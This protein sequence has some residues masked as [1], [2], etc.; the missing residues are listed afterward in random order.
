MEIEK[1]QIF[2]L[3]N[4]NGRRHDVLNALKLYLEILWEI[5]AEYPEETWKR[6]P[7]SL[8]QFLFYQ[9][10]LDYSPEIFKKH[11]KYDGFMGRLGSEYSLFL[12]RN[13]KWLTNHFSSGDRKV[14]DEA[15]EARARHY[16]SNL[17]KIG[18][19]DKQRALSQAGFSYLKNQLE[20]DPI[21]AAL[22]LDNI[23]LIL[24]RQMLK[25]RVFSQRDEN[26]NRC[27][28]SP[29]CMAMFLLLNNQTIDK[30]SFLTIVQGLSPYLPEEQKEFVLSHPDLIS[31]IEKSVWEVPVNPIKELMSSDLLSPEIFHKYIK[32]QKSGLVGSLYYDFYLCLVKFREEK[33]QEAFEELM[34]TLTS[35]KVK[36][37]KAFGYGKAIFE[38]NKH[39]PTSLEE[40]WEKNENHIFFT[41]TNFNRDFYEVFFKSSRVDDIKEY[42]DTTERIL[43]ATGLFKFQSLPE[44]AYREAL[45]LIFDRELLNGMIF[46][47]VSEKE[48][49]AYE[50]SA[51]CIFRSSLSVSA[52]L[53][54]DETQIEVV[55]NQLGALLGADGLSAI[56]A[57]LKSRI[58]REFAAYISKN[59]P[60]E[61]VAKLLSLF[62]DRNNDSKIQKQVN[63]TATVPTI[64]EYLVGIAWYYVSGQ[65]FDLYNSLNLTLNADFEP[66][67]HAGSGE[68]DIIIDYEDRTVML[69]VTLM[70]KQ[71]Q[72]R[73]EWE[74]V[75]RHSLNLK[76]AREPK[77]TMTF[78]IADELDHN[79]IN[80]WRA[81]TSVSL[82]STNTHK[83]V[84]GVI[85]MPFTNRQL[86]SFL[87][88]SVSH[89]AIIEKVKQSFQKVPR[90]TDTK[91]HEEIID[92]LE[93][94]S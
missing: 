18:F 39:N 37:E 60:K 24:L 65:N 7:E 93:R 9:K 56:R 35:H 40:F 26:G 74:P 85:I 83:H 23:N 31:K 47:T 86:L 76:A 4:T 32:N 67:I 14:L 33:S 6:Y 44:L 10:A 94:L 5:K 25:L 72:K 64:Y 69:E 19:A 82:E 48:Y 63:D 54:Y 3:W 91:W 49:Q 57:K 20:R 61:K 90:I 53:H 70:N 45:S 73:G 28:Y 29:F 43:G 30:S 36:L 79:T 11:D 92:S 55:T 68:G 12:G 66:V 27:F 16:T 75:L 17:V 59:Y 87:K 71:A 38:W 34:E 84:D 51:D 8:A 13:P 58:S 62:S 21:E 81:V 15:I 80:I 22:P 50:E 52:I 88:S 1:N 78:F 89:S 42:S 41:T 46:G 77:E 2:N